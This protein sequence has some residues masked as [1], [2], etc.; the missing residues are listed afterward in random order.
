[1]GLRNISPGARF[2]AVKPLR[3]DGEPEL[4]SLAPG[5]E[6]DREPADLDDPVFKGMVDKGDLDVDGGRSKS[7]TQLQGERNKLQ[8]QLNEAT[9]KL[10]AIED[11]RLAERVIHDPVHLERRAQAM[12]S[13]TP[14]ALP[15]ELPKAEPVDN[16]G[17]E[18]V[19]ASSSRSGGGR[20]ERPEPPA[21]AP[22]K[23]G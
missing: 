11:E 1:M 6:T 13:A 18:V 3:G 5:Q 19:K 20:V 23:R 16:R 14:G 12:A 15:H 22:S 21:P 4:I 7:L 9:A 2:I 8:E 10:M 17:E